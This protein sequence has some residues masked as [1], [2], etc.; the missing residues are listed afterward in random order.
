MY[1]LGEYERINI[2]ELNLRDQN[3]DLILLQ[4]HQQ[5]SD[6]K[7]LSIFIKLHIPSSKIF[8]GYEITGKSVWTNQR[9]YISIMFLSKF[10]TQS[11]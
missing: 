7:I 10:Y 6:T 9:L 11:R 3:F 8:T 5:T 2:H 1:I 4:E